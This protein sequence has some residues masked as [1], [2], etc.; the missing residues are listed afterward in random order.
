MSARSFALDAAVESYVESLGSAEAPLLRQLREETQ[1]LPNSSMQ[2]GAAQ[3]AFMTLLAHL[4]NAKRYL[5]LGVF[6]GYSSLAMA[7]TLPEDGRVTGCDISEEYT[8]TAR[9]YWKSAGVEHKID[10]KIGPALESLDAL[11][12][13]GEQG[14][15]DLAFIDADKP[16]IPAYLEKCLVLVRHKG[17][18]LVDNTLRGGKVLGDA[19]DD[20]DTQVLRKFNR[21]IM[22]DSRVEAMLLPLYDG[23]T[24]IRKK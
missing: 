22:A 1:K 17:L 6:T 20:D 18:I 14:T 10:L 12:A 13:A 21:D 7:L 4:L 19:P 23:L 3:G 15:Y 2:I 16:S 24:L 11:I 8:R 5:E 9:E